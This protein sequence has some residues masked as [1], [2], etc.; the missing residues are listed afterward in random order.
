MNKKELD[1]YCR[2]ACACLRCDRKQRAA[3][4]A[5]V[6]Q[7]AAEVLLEH[8]DADLAALEAALGSPEEAAAAF[9]ATL[10]PDTPARWKKRQRKLLLALGATILLLAITVGV[11]V[12][13]YGLFV[14][15]VNTTIGSYEGDVPY[16]LMPTPIPLQ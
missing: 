11:L 15:T 2:R 4:S 16:E 7:N 1:R 3:F 10:P 14:I 8:S 9:M 6:R 13:R 5:L 12:T